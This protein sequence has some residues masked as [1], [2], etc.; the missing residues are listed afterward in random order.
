MKSRLRRAKRQ[1]VGLGIPP[2]PPRS[3]SSSSN[4]PSALHESLK[5]CTI[6]CLPQRERLLPSGGRE[7]WRAYCCHS[8]PQAAGLLLLGSWLHPPPSCILSGSKSLYWP[9]LGEGWLF[10]QQ[11][12]PR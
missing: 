5:Q 8:S 12:V 9:A 1:G 2:F 4:L 3:S 10:G 11:V 7:R 6:L